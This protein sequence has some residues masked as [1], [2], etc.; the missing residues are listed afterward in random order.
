MTL[1]LS[2]KLIKRERE[3]KRTTN[4]LISIYLEFDMGTMDPFGPV[5]P[6]AMLRFELTNALLVLT[7]LA[8]A[9]MLS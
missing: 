4:E 3:K 8:L 9:S 7:R 1:F 6:T 2:K 5:F